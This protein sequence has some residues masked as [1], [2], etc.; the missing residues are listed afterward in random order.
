MHVR[1]LIYGAVVIALAACTTPPAPESV[2]FTA[3]APPRFDAAMADFANGDKAA[4]PPKC[5]TLFVGSSTIRRWASLKEDFPTR[6]VI[7]RGFG[8]STVW[9]V[10]AYFDKVVTPYHPK[11]IVF[12][13]GDNDLSATPERDGRPAQPGRTPDQVYGDF[14]TFMKLKDRDLG[15]TP[16]WFIAVKPSKLRWD[17]Q[18]RMTAVNAKVKALADRRDDLAYIDIVAV[19]LKPDGTPKDIFVEDNLHMTAEGYALWGPIVNK[20]LD[21][22]QK[23]KA[24]GC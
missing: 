16:V 1:T 3:P 6:T 24:P 21:A 10:D 18:D 14:E 22:G 8:G 23:A 12:Y 19:M 5:A 2:A 9:E 13:A 15:Q 11:A 7:N 20:A 17:I 4:M